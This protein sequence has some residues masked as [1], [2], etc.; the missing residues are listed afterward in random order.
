MPK[1]SNEKMQM[2]FTSNGIYYPLF[3]ESVKLY[4]SLRIHADGEFPGTMIKERRPSETEEI[5]EYRQATYKPITKLPISKVVTSFSK[6]R[7]SPDWCIDFPKLKSSKITD[8]E[9]LEK[10]C[11]EKLPGYGSITNWLFGLLIKQNLIDANAVIA[12]IPL[13][14]IAED[15]YT[16]PIPIIFNSNQIVEFNEKDKYAILRSK[17]KV[18]YMNEV[19]AYQDGDI[20]YY[21]DDKE[22]IIYE[23]RKG[24]FEITFQQVNIIGQFPVFKVKAEAYKQ[25]DNLSLSRSRI[26][27]MVPFL[28]EAACEYSDLK[29]S[30]IQHLYPLFWYYQNKNCNSCG[31]IGNKPSDNGPVQCTSCGGSGKVKFSPFAHLQIDPA[32]L[33]KQANPMP[34]AGYITRDTAILELQEKSVEKNNY[35]ALAAINMQFLDQTPLSISGEAKQ[36]DREELNNTVYNFAEDLV[37]SADKVIYF[38]NE[39]RYFFLVPDAKARME[40]LPNIPV[41]QN[42]DLLPEDYLMKEVTDARTAKINPLLIATLEQ[43]LAAKKFYNQPNLA[44]NIK[45]YFDLDP[46]PGVSTDEKLSMLSNKGCTQTDYIISNYMASFIKRALRED[47][48]FGEKNYDVQMEVLIKYAEEKIKSND[49]ASQMVDAQKQQVIAEM[50]QQQSPAQ[51]QN[52]KPNNQAA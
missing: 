20:F 3:T 22:I 44:N 19:N 13:E 9:T 2:Y 45:L 26:D 42:F 33:G 17:R 50:Q 11:S 1:I 15:I 51:Q 29:G 8:D 14:N 24:G 34:P 10:Y 39:W 4:D 35:K 6:I 38:I 18:S 5:L 23:Q 7:R 28:D 21:I 27:A 40:M 31:G 49:E 37:Y 36:V 47:E 48:K 46:L 43:Q 52:T 16:K 41:P 32:E 12:V 30:K 25:Y